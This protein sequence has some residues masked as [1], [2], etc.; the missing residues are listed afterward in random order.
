ML[1]S[2]RPSQIFG[3]EKFF[4]TFHKTRMKVP[5]REKESEEKGIKKSNQ[6]NEIFIN[7]VK[8]QSRGRLVHFGLD[9][10][11]VDVEGINLSIPVCIV[12]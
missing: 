8:G 11:V 7:V 4:I 6:S 5:E 3:E 2:S 12:M 1:F 9:V 10:I